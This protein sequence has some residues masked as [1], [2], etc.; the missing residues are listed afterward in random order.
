MKNKFKSMKQTTAEQHG[1]T[2]VELAIVLVVV[3]LLLAMVI[4]SLGAQRDIR[5]RNETQH[6]LN[7]AKEALIGYAVVNRH[8]PCPDTSDFPNGEENRVVAAGVN[9]CQADEGILPWKTLGIE[10]TDA[11]NHYFGYR[12]DAT[13]SNVV[14]VTGATFAI[15]DAEGASL[16][17]LKD[18][19]GADLVS[20]GSRPAAV[21]FSHGA[22]GR[23]A[24]NTS[25]VVAPN[26]KQPLPPATAL[27][28]IENTDGDLVFVTHPPTLINSTNEFDDMLVWVPPKI[29]INRMVISGRLP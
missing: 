9:G 25:Q 5:N 22:N 28:E 8:F 29:L 26:N 4:P 3:G 11:W 2:L 18:E 19:L 7:Q 23:G 17:E 24:T 6:L 14:V 20:A 27:D 15:D 1:F 12:V 13:F 21:V 16:I 10:N